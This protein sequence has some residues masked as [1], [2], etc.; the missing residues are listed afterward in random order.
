MEFLKQNFEDKEKIDLFNSNLRKELLDLF[1]TKGVFIKGANRTIY[2]DLIFYK[3]LNN[4]ELNKIES[5]NTEFYNNFG[6]KSIEIIKKNFDELKLNS[7][8]LEF[9]DFETKE[10][11]RNL[12]YRNIKLNN[13]NDLLCQKKQISF[14]EFREDFENEILKYIFKE[15]RKAFFL[16]EKFNSQLNDLRRKSLDKINNDS[17]N[18]LYISIGL[19]SG[20]LN[21]KSQEKIKINAPTLLLPVILKKTEKKTF[22]LRIDLTRDFQINKDIILLFNRLKKKNTFIDLTSFDELKSFKEFNFEKIEKEI[23]DFYSENGLDLSVKNPYGNLEYKTEIGLGTFD[24]YKNS[25]ELDLEWILQSGFVTKNIIGLFNNNEENSRINEISGKNNEEFERRKQELIDKNEYEVSYI[26]KINFPQDKAVKGSKIY[27]NIVIQGP[28]GTGKTE[29]ITSI[30]SD[31]ILRNKKVLVSSEK[32]VAINVIKSRMGELAKYALLFKGNYEVVDFYDQLNFMISES[33]KDKTNQSNTSLIMSDNEILFRRQE[34]RKEIIEYMKEYQDIFQ[35]LKSNEIGKT[36][37]WLYKNH[38]SYRT[39]EPKIRKILENCT[40]SQ[41]IRENKLFIPKLYDILLILNQKFSYKANVDEFDLDKAALNKYPFLI[42]HTKK[43]L[44]KAKINKALRLINDLSDEMIFVGKEFSGL[45]KKALSIVFLDVKHLKTYLKTKSEIVKIIELLNAKLRQVEKNVDETKASDI[46]NMLGSSWSQTFNEIA[47]ELKKRNKKI[48]PS[49]VS[50]VIFDNVIQQILTIKESSNAKLQKNISNGNINSFNQMISKALQDIVEKNITLTGRKLRDKLLDVL[51]KSG[52]MVEIQSIIENQKGLSVNKFMHKYWKEIFESVSIWL[53]PIEN[54]Q[55]FFPLVPEM[56]DVVIID[57]A[58]QME[59]QKA[60]PLMF[61]AKKLVISG[62]DKQLKPSVNPEEIIYFNPEES[63]W[64][65]TILPPLGLQ[66]SLKN[67]YI[68]FL[69]NYHYRSKYSELIS[70]SNTFFYNKNLYVSTPKAYDSKNPPI[71]FVKVNDAKNINGKNEKEAIK[72]V[73]RII[74]QIQEDPKK[75]IGVISFT[76]EQKEMIQQ[77]LDEE[78]AKNKEL[79]LF[80]RTNKFGGDGEDTSLFVQNVSE[81]QGDERDVIIFSI[82]FSEDENGNLPTNL[83]FI[84]RENGENTLN[85]AITRAKVKMIVCSSIDAND[86]EIPVTDIGGQLLKHFL[87]YALAFQNAD[88]NVVR[89]ILKLEPISETKVFESKMHEEIFNLI[90]NNGYN[91]EYKFGFDN[92]KIDFAIKDENENVILGINLDNEQYLR[93]FN[94]MEREYYLPTYLESRGW[95]I[96]RI[97]SHQ[98]SKDPESE[99]QLI[100]ERIEDAI[101]AFKNGTLISLYGK[102]QRIL[103]FNGPDYQYEELDESEEII[104]E[105]EKIISE[106]F[107]D[108]RE[109]AKK[110]LSE[111]KQIEEAKWL[112][113]YEALEGRGKGSLSDD[114]GLVYDQEL[115]NKKSRNMDDIEDQE[116]DTLIRLSEKRRGGY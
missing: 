47:D 75:T 76:F 5:I 104:K 41:I 109:S 7:K 35:Y 69:L 44:S 30:I 38:S 83:G 115:K 53:L 29:T 79:D 55:K 37:S 28:P 85:V 32:L 11:L 10:A 43:G 68:N 42:T 64:K 111:K 100:L 98:W 15:E 77:K 89:R 3:P 6:K 60:I 17:Y 114:F 14:L 13:K 112:A 92:Y 74:Q 102:N 19:I 50:G 86:L 99:N 54:I 63:D 65:K 8:N 62:D 87:Y 36:Y 39:T 78:A 56:F 18:N 88:A 45:A 34:A 48:I 95:N 40:V 61:R 80:I 97:W 73:E 27:D 33:L 67:K 71:E 24:V 113:E 9:I 101:D 4:D 21:L 108:I 12:L 82:A 90:R 70:F 25:T 23:F 26:S 58:S 106:K 52:K 103:D 107:K 46:Y 1:T 91:V 20:E 72:V 84:S 49:L 66:D 57:E 51:I 110:Y 96:I 59:V 93:N 2:N 116:I 81:V 105:G 16:N 22:Y 94:T 31:A